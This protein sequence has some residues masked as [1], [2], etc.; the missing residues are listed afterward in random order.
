MK[1]QNLRNTYQKIT[2]S[3]ENRLFTAF[4]VHEIHPYQVPMHAKGKW[5]HF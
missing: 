1:I 3:A 4:L 5:A 2:S